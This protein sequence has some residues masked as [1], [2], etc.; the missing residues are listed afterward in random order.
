MF[1]NEFI[2]SA[3]WSAIECLLWSSTIS[4]EEREQSPLLED[5]EDW[6]DVDAPVSPDALESMRQDVIGFLELAESAIVESG[7]NSEQVGR[8]FTLTRN[9]HG[10]GFW[11]RGLGET[12]E[13][14]TDWAT[15]FG[16]VECLYFDSQDFITWD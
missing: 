9:G 4:E 3:T 5:C 15:T 6:D 10:A 1:A 11:D 2:D 8:D 14:L 7:L 12:G 16:P 13:T